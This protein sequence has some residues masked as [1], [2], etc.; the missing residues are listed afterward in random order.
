MLKG[1]NVATVFDDAEVV[2]G[3]TGGGDAHRGDLGGSD[4][5]LLADGVAKGRHI[6]GNLGGG[7]LGARRNAVLA[8]DLKI[9]VD[10]ARGDVGAAQ[11]D[12]NAIH[13][14][15]SVFLLN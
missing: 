8:D 5:C 7:T 4:P 10:D 13:S 11:V 15:F 2:V 1:G 3:N 14:A 9:F 6:G 12:T